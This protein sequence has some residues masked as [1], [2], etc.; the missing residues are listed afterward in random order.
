MTTRRRLLKLTAETATF[1][2]LRSSTFLHAQDSLS[3]TPRKHTG[4]TP[5]IEL[6]QRFVDLR[7]GMFLHFNMATFQDLEWGDPASPSSLFSPTALDTD[8]WAAAAKS[9][10]MTW[11]CLTTRHHDGFC[12]WPTKTHAASVRQ[13]SHS[14]DVVRAYVN[15]FRAAGL[16]V[17]LYYSILSKRDDIRHYNITPEKIH[18]VKSQLTELF[19]EYGEIDVLITDGWNAPWSRITYEEMPFREIYD[20]VK[21]LQPNCLISDL[22]A[23]Q[24]PAGG[25]YYSDIKAFEQNA[26]QK[27][28]Q[29]SDL[30]ALSCVTL[31]PEWFWKQRDSQSELKSVSTVV[32]EWLVPLNKRFCTLILNAPPTREGRLAKNVVDRLQEIGRAWKN[33]GQDERIGKHTVITTMNLATGKPIH[34]SSY[35]DGNGPD[36]ANDQSFQTAWHLGTGLSTGWLEVDLLKQQS[37]NV[38]SLV[39]PVGSAEIY[40]YSRISSYRFEHWDGANWVILAEGRSP[41]SATILTIPMVTARRV[42]LSIEASHDTPHIAD[43]GI[44]NEIV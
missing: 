19:T 18:L 32:D 35:P 43:F 3:S 28:P 12:I 5:L 44:Y 38:L 6:Q 20:H 34:A 14:I 29:K 23:S 1:A 17:G 11:S 40:Q 16:R 33:T 4:K 37:F 15:S 39:E 36:Q 26:G 22:N 27:V 2:L 25:L 41:M 21:A 9:A 30:P 8:Q 10:N 24:F 7:F 42:R 31:T 13:T